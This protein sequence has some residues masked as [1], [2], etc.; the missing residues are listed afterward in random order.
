[1]GGERCFVDSNIWLYAFIRKPD[2]DCRHEQARELVRRCRDI[3]VSEQGIAEVSSN[4]LKKGGFS[5]ERLS[6]IVEAFYRRYRVF[7]PALETHLAAGRLRGRYHLSYWDSL[8]VAAALQTDSR[9]LYSEDMQSGLVI[10]GSL[11]IIKPLLKD[12]G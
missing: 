2:E 9:V 7:A 11:R 6:P 8:I 3:A 1:M 5:E 12:V 10:D 4:L